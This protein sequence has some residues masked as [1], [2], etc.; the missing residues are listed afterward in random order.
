MKTQSSIDVKSVAVILSVIVPLSVF[1]S[2]KI[3]ASVGQKAEAI[4]DKAASTYVRQDVYAAN[5]KSIMQ[6]LRFIARATGARLLK[7]E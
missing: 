3:D 6:Q 5:Q 4:E 2:W 1:L 7:E